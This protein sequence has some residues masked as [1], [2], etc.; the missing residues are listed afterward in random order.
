MKVGVNIVLTKAPLPEQTNG[1]INL[2]SVNHLIGK[3]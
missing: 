3:N 1:L 2:L